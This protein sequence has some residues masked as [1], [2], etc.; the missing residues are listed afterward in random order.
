MSRTYLKY[1]IV[2]LILASGKLSFGQVMNTCNT[3]FY[4]T[5]GPNGNY[6]NNEDY[7]VTYCADNGGKMRALF[8]DFSLSS[9]F[10]P[11]TL[12]VYDGPSTFSNI[13][14]KYSGSLSNPG[15]EFTINSLIRGNGA[16]LTFEFKSG[17]SGSSSGWEAEIY[18]LAPP[19]GGIEICGDGVD[20]DADGLVDQADPD[21][22]IEPSVENCFVGNFYYIPP[23]WQLN[24]TDDNELNGPASLIFSTRYPA[25]QINVRTLDNSYNQDFGI[26]NAS[27]FV[28]NI[29]L[30]YLQT[31][32]PNQRESNKGFIVSSDV[33]ISINYLTDGLLNKNHISIRGREGLGRGFRVGSQ[34]NTRIASA[35]TSSL[36]EAHFISV[37]A[38]EDETDVTF[39]FDIPMT[40]ITSPHTVRLN[41]G[42]SYL[43]KD[44]DN[45]VSVSGA[46][47]SASKNIAVIS[48]SQYTQ[49][50][51]TTAQ[52]G[53][54]DQIIPASKAGTNYVLTRSGNDSDQDYA[55]VVPIENGTNIFLDGAF[56]QTS[57]IDAG[58]YYQIPLNGSIGDPLHIRTSR[59][60]MV[61]HISGQNGGNVGLA[62]VPPIGS[63]RGDNIL[64]FSK[65]NTADNHILNIVIPTSGISDLRLNGGPV[66]GITRA[67]PGFAGFSTI[68]V[69]EAGLQDAN[70]L[71]AST[72]FTAGLVAS[73]SQATIYSYLTSYR[74]T[75][76]F[77][78]V[79]TGLPIEYI[80]LDTL[81]NGSGFDYFFQVE[82]CGTGHRL[83]SI[84][85][86]GNMGVAEIIDS[87]GL[88]IRFDSEGINTGQNFIS[89]VVENNLGNRSSICV[90]FFVDDL[91]V[92]LGE[93]LS[94]CLEAN[95]T[96]NATASGGAPPYSYTWSNGATSASIE[97]RPNAT[98]RYFVTVTDQ[99]A[100]DFVDDVNISVGAG[101]Q[102]ACLNQVNI[103]LNEICESQ[104][105]PEILLVKN[106]GLDGLFTVEIKDQWGFVVPNAT[107]DEYYIGKTLTY[108]VSTA[109]DNS[110]WGN[111]LVEDKYIPIINC[112]SYD[113]L[114]SDDISPDSIGYPVPFENPIVI[115][116]NVFVLSG[117]DA[118]SDVTLSYTEDIFDQE[119]SSPLERIIYRNWLVEDESGNKNSCSDTIN[120]FKENINTVV[121]PLN[122]DDLELPALECDGNYPTFEN[123]HPSTDPSAGG[124]LMLEGCESIQVTFNDTYIESC[125]TSFKILRDWR[126]YDWCTGLT[127][128]HFQVIKVADKEAPT[129]ACPPPITVYTSPYEC[130]TGLIIIPPPTMQDNCNQT[131]FSVKVDITENDIFGHPVDENNVVNDLSLGIHTVHYTLFDACNNK[132]TC[133]TIITVEDNKAPFAIAD[134][135]TVASIG[136]D[137]S[138]RI[139]AE[140]FD[141][142]SFDNCG[143]K[144]M[145]VRKKVDSCGTVLGDYLYEGQYF[146]DFVDFCCSEVGNEDL[147]VQFLV[148]DIH[149]NVNVVWV[150]VTLNDKL[151]P[152][153]SAPPN[154]TISCDHDF[155]YDDLSVFGEV[156][157]GNEA[158]KPIVI[159]DAYNNG[160]VGLDGFAVDNCYLEVYEE[161]EIDLEC[162]AG[163]IVRTFIAEDNNGMTDIA[164]QVITVQISDPFT[165]EQIIWPEKVTIEGCVNVDIDT[166]VTGYPSY[167]DQN[168]AKLA[169]EYHDKVFEYADGACLAIHRE[170]EVLDWCQ[171]NP[172]TGEGLWKYIQVIYV[173]NSTEPVYDIDYQDT[174]VCI[175][176]TCEGLV[177]LEVTATDDCTSDLFYKW[178]VD[179]DLDG[180]YDDEGV[181]NRIQ[182]VWLPGR[183]YLAWSVEDLCGNVA[184]EKYYVSV[185]DCKAPTPYCISGIAT[186]IMPQTGEIQLWA[187]DYNIGSFDNC[188]DISDL[189]LSFSK[190]TSDT[191][192]TVSCEMMDNGFQQTLP[193]KV[194]VTDEAGN[195]DFCSVQVKVNDNFDVCPDS[196]FGYVDFAGEVLT[197]AKDYKMENVQITLETNSDLREVA[198]TEVDGRFRFENVPDDLEYK[199]RAVFDEDYRSGVTTLDIILI[200]KHI[201]GVK[202]MTDPYQL[203]AADVSNSGS[204]SGLDLIQIRKLILGINDNFP[205]NSSWRFVDKNYQFSDSSKPWGWQEY[206][207]LA[208][209]AGN[210]LQADLAGVK[211]GDVN[212]SYSGQGMLDASVRQAPFRVVGE[213][214]RFEAGEQVRVILDVSESIQVEGFQVAFNF[215]KEILKLLGVKGET[216]GLGADH[217]NADLQ[218]GHIAFS[219]DK[220]GGIYVGQKTGIIELTFQAKSSG[221][222]SEALSIDQ[223]FI[224]P[225][226]YSYTG[227]VRELTL[228]FRSQVSDLETD[229]KVVFHQNQPNPWM[230]STVIDFELP[231]SR[232]VEFKLF[233]I[234]GRLVLSQTR[235]Y[236]AGSHQL[237]VNN[238]NLVKAGIY[239]YQVTAGDF[240]G[241]GKMVFT[242]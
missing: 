144:L 106:S 142:G 32:S 239:Y 107:I 11:D 206:V 102:I 52:D 68:L 192:F 168:C 44:D 145:K 209:I 134:K 78:D 118:C 121:F 61:Y 234:S 237:L 51:G 218:D 191:F 216:I 204:I 229:S 64:S 176:G 222:L 188:T 205:K 215:S 141:D 220:I 47:V 132:D 202:V 242:R 23:I 84:E 151:P 186:A 207:D 201:L 194:W 226:I 160:F 177:D 158:R 179:F 97:V 12:Y 81:C 210:Y 187:S 221:L 180:I 214:Q 80:D 67:V 182:E 189:K 159:N 164:T 138:T 124:G 82:S 22:L 227:D 167:I 236:E 175:Y 135:H 139:Y 21:C 77:L 115:E 101:P 231:D 14:G 19:Q 8:K 63:C 36:K 127:R 65:V 190:D 131:D 240:Q 195:Q 147:R 197:A 111:L 163:Q 4:D 41:R 39:T 15:E 88:G 183:Y 49:A 130:S 96:L 110:C 200:Q 211:I 241:S 89:V 166:M 40:G 85:E 172:A 193:L 155:Y 152:I 223:D 45:N 165:E 74:E 129:F 70:L 212:G 140:N 123:G 60:A 219:F 116:N 28:Q 173:E 69:Q 117:V 119:C 95:F 83:I 3:T 146:H 58:D 150:E 66:S 136:S 213:D 114:C 6:S 162:G 20:N 153:I 98:T 87:S 18:C 90:G 13:I 37:M 25:A 75:I 92:E 30:S 169:A 109:C 112:S 1:L 232:T 93:D 76:D 228:D 178:R 133:E 203:I 86:S 55:I 73:S 62:V 104:I 48:G 126:L 233:D 161:V 199:V 31:A 57:T 54:M 198:F 137:G 196:E 7:L 99:D 113:V 17:S 26:T 35:S 2:F 24:A 184:F 181:G 230:E 9:Q 53:G 128:Q 29:P 149:G 79:V 122:R 72:N 43:I 224:R 154:I 33:P 120:V 156:V 157:Q 94:T 16:C 208:G 185:E 100:C 148:E 38:S 71:T 34:T 143:I 42:E 103:S 217:Y 27:E 91:S 56:I 170:W 50:F 5:G 171:Y 46:L 238:N 108:T 105:T 59:P 174:T 125:G 225:E 10:I 235:A